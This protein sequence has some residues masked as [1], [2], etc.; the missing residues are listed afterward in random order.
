MQLTIY[1]DYSLR[2]LL[3]LARNPDATSTITEV[4]NFYKISR[5]HLV[6][7]VHQLAQLGYIKSLRGKNGGIQ[8]ARPANEIN[9]AEVVKKTEKTFTLVEC[10]DE[11]K[12]QCAITGY[13]KLKGILT[14]ALDAYLA[15]LAKYTIADACD[16]RLTSL[17]KHVLLK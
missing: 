13:C 17:I 3:F 14:Q 10:F 4:A 9:I 16:E 11:V 12:N 8:L 2:V 5:N 6:K 1:T 15:E 7:V